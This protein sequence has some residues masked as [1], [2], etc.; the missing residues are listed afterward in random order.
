MYTEKSG[1]ETVNRMN[2]QEVQQLAVQK[3]LDIVEDT[4]LGNES[5]LDFQVFHAEDKAGDKWILRLPRRSDSMAKAAQEKAVLDAVNRHTSIEAPVTDVS[6]DFAAHYLI[7]GD[8]GLD[9]VMAAY[10]NA[11]GRIWP[12]MKEHIIELRAAEA[13]VVAEFAISSVLKDME[14]M[15]RQMLGVT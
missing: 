12:H 6:R 14:D 13:V 2:K 11:G 3:G 15:T 10:E 9:K 4:L 8:R 5:G 7:F 1:E